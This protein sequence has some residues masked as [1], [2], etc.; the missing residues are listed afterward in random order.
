MPKKYSELFNPSQ[1]L[2]IQDLYNDFITPEEIAINVLESNN[3]GEKGSLNKDQYKQLID[4]LFPKSGE[5]KSGEEIWRQ[6]SEFV[7]FPKPSDDSNEEREAQAQRFASL[8]RFY[9]Y[10]GENPSSVE[11]E[12]AE[13]YE[14]YRPS[15]YTAYDVSQISKDEE[16]EE[17]N[18]TGYVPRTLRELLNASIETEKKEKIKSALS[19]I[20]VDT[21]AIDLKLKNADIVT[22]FLNYMPGVIASQL[23][24]YLDVRFSFERKISEAEK[25]SRPQTS[26]TPL[27]FLMGSEPIPAD[28]P[29]GR[30]VSAL[31]YDAYTSNVLK[32][33][34]KLDTDPLE[35]LNRQAQLQ[36]D[37][38]ANQQRK[39]AEK[40]AIEK[41]AKEIQDNIKKNESKNN[42]N[43]YIQTTTTGME[44]FTMPQTLINLDYDE[45]TTPRY[46]SVLNRTVP[47]GTILSFNVNVTS[48]GYGVFSYKT[49]VL[50]LKIFDKSRIVEIADF[51]NPKLYGSA[52][53]WITYGW[54]A[55]P[56]PQN[57]SENAYFSMIN[58]NMLKKEAYGISN[59]SIS[60]S[61]DGSATVTLNL[62]MRFARELT[63]I[64]P[65]AGS[66]IFENQKEI[67]EQKYSEVKELAEKLGFNNSGAKDIRGGTIIKSALGGNS[68]NL[69]TVAI[70]QEISSLR[71]ALSGNT[72]PDAQR[73][74][75]LIEELYNIP[76]GGKSTAQSNLERAARVAVSG[77]FE[78]LR[79]TSSLDMWSAI[80]VENSEN[81]FKDDPLAVNPH[82]LV[83]MK[84]FLSDHTTVINAKN[85]KKISDFGGISF[86]RLF[87]I[88]FA[89]ATKI[90]Q[91]GKTPDID[92]YQI[93][94]YNFNKYAGL[95][96]N[97]NIA[98][99]PIDQKKLEKSYAEYV[100]KQNGE[101]MTLLNFLE[102]VRSSQFS[103]MAHPA[104]GYSDF[105]DEEGKVRD[106]KADQL[107]KS[108]MNNQGLGSGF[109]APMID[110][111]VETSSVHDKT[112]ITD[113]LTSFELSSISSSGKQNRPNGIKKIV[114]I[115]IYDK[116][117]I[118]HDAAFTLLRTTDGSFVEVDNS[119][120]KKLQQEEE[121]KLKLPV[122]QSSKPE[123]NSPENQVVTYEKNRITIP[124]SNV[125]VEAKSFSAKG[126]DGKAR[127][128]NL[129]KHIARFVPTLTIGSNGTTI[130]SVNYSSEQDAM[131]STIMMIR[132]KH[133]SA[134]PSLP[135]GSGVGDLPLRV[136]PGQLSMTTMGCPLLEYMQQFFVDLGTGTTIDNL[137]N[138]T[139]LTHTMTPGVFTSDVKFTFVDAYGKYE[140]A[141]DITANITATLQTVKKKAE[142]AA[143]LEA[144]NNPNKAP[145]K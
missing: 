123:E 92:E 80:S 1:R 16:D 34:I 10:S 2:K 135:N 130:K 46:N 93:V 95:V 96:S 25:Q 124:G 126:S 91:S 22:T 7:S 94:F 57:S 81:K 107:Q 28:D 145:K 89:S 14:N 26:M 68:P 86:A 109:V 143:K 125:V 3:S 61:D 13:F 118:A 103:N 69:D 114:R 37:P 55:P 64:S 136:I 105:Y 113:L 40:E 85:G 112:A 36:Q 67:F 32:Q 127:F 115:H 51:L 106:N 62:F 101:K 19:L 52:T 31:I 33:N 66:T 83:K 78:K 21:A 48:A 29:S 119:Y 59:S 110:F 30:A 71:S 84:N 23:T 144:K 8:I 134:S 39:Q 99:F 133:S 87:S 43:Q 15:A 6:F 137:Y 70:Q 97:L 142:E 77:R 131:L 117:S 72:S 42:T 108:L 73:F 132:N 24:P 116:A 104:F 54:R 74:I 82:P 5:F 56:Q 4:L 17:D 98:E 60:I 88:Y 35:L 120:V 12:I 44:M 76:Q 18:D 65:T 53:L 50:T 100:V 9:Y 45:K 58:E 41:S 75:S 102:I 129:K 47:F 139:N 27:K 128:E 111:F 138:I 90:L 49:A 38:R 20:L 63:Q 141:N 140:G 11:D 79:V 121:A 122:Q